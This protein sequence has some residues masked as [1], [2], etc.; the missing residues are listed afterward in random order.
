MS[1]VEVVYFWRYRCDI[2]NKMVTT[3]YKTTR[4]RVITEHP[5]ATP[6]ESSREERRINGDPFASSTSG[7]LRGV[8]DIGNGIVYD[9]DEKKPPT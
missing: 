6:V 1:T 5:D 8:K 2:R 7:F 3:R 4:E 9:P